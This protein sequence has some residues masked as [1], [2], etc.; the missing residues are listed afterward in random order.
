MSFYFSSEF[1]SQFKKIIKNNAD[2][3]LEKIFIDEIISETSEN[4]LNVGTSNINSTAYNLLIK[5]RLKREGKGKSSS[6]RTYFFFR[7]KNDVFEFIYVYPKTGRRSQTSITKQDLKNLL[8]RFSEDKKNGNLTE[9]C[10]SA[11]GSK[12]INKNT[13]KNI[14]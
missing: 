2:K 7:I 1:I 6:Y 11:D 12:I 9:I 3:N 14:F 8:K 10:L 5:K 13:K 4:I